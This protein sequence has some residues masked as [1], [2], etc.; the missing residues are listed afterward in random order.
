MFKNKLKRDIIALMR[1][2]VDDLWAGL[3][4]W[5]GLFESGPRPGSI[6]MP[7]WGIVMFYLV[8]LVGYW[9]INY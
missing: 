7:M 2:S 9:I 5:R 3:W 1:L 8:G 6:V 4:G